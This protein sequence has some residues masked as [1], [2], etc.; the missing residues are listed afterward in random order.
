MKRMKYFL[1]F[2]LVITACGAC[3]NERSQTAGSDKTIY[4]CTMHHVVREYK[5]VQCP[6]CGMDLV[7]IPDINDW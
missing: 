3:G 7:I 6:I 2:I 1:S 5:D 4:S